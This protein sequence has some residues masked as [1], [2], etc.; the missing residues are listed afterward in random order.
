[1]GIGN[2]MGDCIRVTVQRFDSTRFDTTPGNGIKSGVYTKSIGK[3]GMVHGV[4]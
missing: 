2:G 3:G 4:A 1:M